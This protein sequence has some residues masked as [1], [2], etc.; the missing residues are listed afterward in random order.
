M[1]GTLILTILITCIFT[2]LDD[3]FTIR[4][5]L[6]RLNVSLLLFLLYSLLVMAVIEVIK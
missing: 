1:I 2:L 5:L 3:D 6:I 4:K